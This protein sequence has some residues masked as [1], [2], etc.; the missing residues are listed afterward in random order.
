MKRREFLHSALVLP[1]GALAGAG[2]APLAGCAHKP[3]A[4]AAPGPAAPSPAAPPVA[5]ASPE[6]AVCAGNDPYAQTLKAID[7]L[8]GMG[9]FVKPGQS[10]V[11]S[12]NLAFA[13]RPE[14]GAATHPRVLRAVLDACQKAGAGQVVV[15]DFVLDA[16]DVTFKVTGA[17]AALEGTNVSFISPDTV[18]QYKK[19]DVSRLPIHA[20]H[21]IEQAIANQVLAAD[22]LI[23]MPVIKH[24]G[25]S[26]MSGALKKNMGLVWLRKAYHDADL[27]GCIA[28]LSTVIQPHLVVA[29]ATRVL[30][31]NGPSGPGELT[32]PKQVLAARNQ[33]L[34]DAYACRY[35]N[36]ALK[37]TD[38]PHVV[39]AAKLNGVADLTNFRIVEVTL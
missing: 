17:Q 25:G 19:F 14:Q 27:H 12:P 16:R 7:A 33:V 26:M 37:P 8:G 36:G 38:I 35:L 31:T 39:Q 2:L 32:H 18:D 10:V 23:N 5:A 11:L 9:Q 6:V 34:A 3:T 28:E 24:H 1:A 13:R 15:L 4:P 29:D 20:A 21:H 22:V 30:Q